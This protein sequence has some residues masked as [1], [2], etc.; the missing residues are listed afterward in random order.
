M[1]KTT[2]SVRELLMQAMTKASKG[3]LSPDEGKMLCNLA[4]QISTSMAVEVKVL[5]LKRRINQTAEVF[6]K[7]EVH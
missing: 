1:S 4:N 5:E 2:G 6:G 3:E 7:L